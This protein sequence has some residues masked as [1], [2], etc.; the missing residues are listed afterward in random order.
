M[1]SNSQE[2]QDFLMEVANTAPSVMKMRIPTHEPIYNIDL[3]TRKVEAPPFIGVEQDHN[4][5]YIF[6]EVDRFYDNIDL[7]NS[8]GV[9]LFKNAKDEEFCQLISYY[10]IYSVQNK[11]IFPW[12]IQASA[13]L[14]SGIVSFSIKFFKIDPTTKELIY[15]LNTQIAKTK[16]LIGWANTKTTDDYHTRQIINNDSIEISQEALNRINTVLSFEGHVQTLWIDL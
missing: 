10:D 4:A 15:E 13:A 1:I 11:I 3:N 14:Y 6:F 5:E 12:V 7:S 9:I 2:Y 8:I 16:V